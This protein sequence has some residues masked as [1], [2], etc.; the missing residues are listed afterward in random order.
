MKNTTFLHKYIFII[1]CVFYCHLGYGQDTLR[2]K[3]GTDYK[4]RPWVDIPLVTGCAAWA[5]YMLTQIY[6]KGPSTQEQILSLDINSINSL[7]RLAIYPYN[8]KMDKMS[9]YPFYAAFPL[10]LVFMLTG[11]PMRN[12]FLKLGFL[13]LES[14]SITGLLGGSATYFVNQYRPYVYTPGTSMDKK[15]T[16]N[17]KNSFYAGHVEVI[18]VSTFFISEVYAGCYPESKIKWMFFVLS[19]AAT[20]GMGYLR[21]DAGMH[22][23]SDVL[24]GGCAGALSGILVPYFHNHKIIKNTNL[25]IVPFGSNTAQGLSMTYAFNK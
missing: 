12:D 19:G 18:A 1:V 11:K 25:N 20:L 3:K 15:V 9:Y 4:L 6:T 14:L 8:A 22:F 16:D 17:A 24:L 21:I 5:G 2:N 10:P 13:Y 7:D 23:P